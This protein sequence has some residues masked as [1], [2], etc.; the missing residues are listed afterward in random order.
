[1]TTSL[2]LKSQL[3][4]EHEP[5]AEQLKIIDAAIDEP[6]LVVA[7]AGSGK[8]ETMSNRITWLIAH[9]RIHPA[10]ILGLTFTRKAVTEL[11]NRVRKRLATYYDKVSTDQDELVGFESPQISSYN[12]FSASIISEFGYLEGI[13][14]NAKVITDTDR[15]LIAEE[16]LLQVYDADLAYQKGIFDEEMNARSFLGEFLDFADELK[17]NLLDPEPLKQW[18]EDLSTSLA[19]RSEHWGR[20]NA[21]AY[22]DRKAEFD[23]GT[24][25]EK[26]SVVAEKIKY[27]RKLLEL[28]ETFEQLK[29]E[30]GVIDFSDQ[31]SNAVQILRLHPEV[32]EVY[33][34]RYQVVILDEYQDTS[35]SQIHLL[36]LLFGD[37]HHVMAVGDPNQ[38]IYGFRGA[39]SGGILRFVDDFPTYK[40][41]QPSRAPSLT[42][43]TSWRNDTSILKA[44]NNVLE[45]VDEVH[46]TRDGAGESATEKPTKKASA[47]DC[48]RLEASPYAKAGNLQVKVC[49]PSGVVEVADDDG[50]AAGAS[51]ADADAGAD[52]SMPGGEAQMQSTGI[53][54]LDALK[55]LPSEV[56]TVADFLQEHF[57]DGQT[58]AIIS[59][60]NPDLRSFAYEL[61]ARGIPYQM[62][63]LK[64]LLDLPEIVDV[65]S[66]VEVALDSGA[67]HKLMRFLTSAQM[68]LAPRDLVEMRKRLRAENKR[69]QHRAP[70]ATPWTLVDLTLELAASHNAADE[71]TPHWQVQVAALGRKILR[72]KEFVGSSASEFIARAIAISGVKDELELL[73]RTRAYAKSQEDDDFSVRAHVNLQELLHQ[74]KNY[75][76][77]AL[78]PSIGGFLEWLAQAR[79]SDNGLEQ[80]SFTPQ[81]DAVTLIT[82]HGA[83]GLEWDIVC[84]VANTLRQFNNIQWNTKVEDFENWR[85]NPSAGWLS[86]T[87][88][89]PDKWRLDSG[90]LQPLADLEDVDSLY[91][92]D[93]HLRRFSEGVAQRGFEERARLAYVAF[94]RAKHHL[95]LTYSPLPRESKYVCHPTPYFLQA[96]KA[97]GGDVYAQTVQA[98]T[99]FVQIPKVPHTPLADQ[100]TTWPYQDASPEQEAF[101]RVAQAVNLAVQGNALA[102]DR[103]KAQGSRKAQDLREAQSARSSANLRDTPHGTSPTLQKLLYER[104]V[105]KALRDTWYEQ[106]SLP[107]LMS[108]SQTVRLAQDK[109]AFLASLA[110]P[111]PGRPTYYN[112]IGTRFHLF[113]EEFFRT[114]AHLL[115]KDA[116]YEYVSDAR[117]PHLSIDA[118]VGNFLRSPFSKSE[119]LS[120]EQELLVT[121]PKRSVITRID[122]VFEDP[123]DASKQLIVDWKTGRHP[124]EQELR[125]L[126]IQLAWYRQAWLV[127]HHELAP[128]SVEAAFFYVK[129]GE[130]G[131]LQRFST[132]YLD[133][134]YAQ[135][136]DMI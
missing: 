29:R 31:V 40:E 90:D 88:S 93:V 32:I 39:S 65:L 11:K 23:P 85:P 86:K 19:A 44:A 66:L 84:S 75:E 33:R 108:T 2:Q 47:N 121:S 96:L 10:Q 4:L 72:L 110:R 115:H 57:K 107:A 73:L 14:A 15:F 27:R 111:V 94:T 103:S 70:E 122:A 8:T 3:G 21:K 38:A 118:L 100:S 136:A 114:H 63:T 80:F 7:G 102:D 124:S 135:V 74:A 6:L 30:R 5:T 59:P 81:K 22:K 87:A 46:D 71:N 106:V 45:L 41:G 113:I 28:V 54:A 48:T 95:L 24:A 78:T 126:S 134:V 97:L 51:N 67:A 109:N 82:V 119:P 112:D 42:L 131:T 91:D 12:A 128:E 132:K 35:P 133:T 56:E 99:Q 58:A 92:Y 18:V 116:A 130:S 129:E 98:I 69:L 50:L 68:G 36:Q 61:K 105:R 125:T 83:K 1:M 17:N 43:L 55:G 123:D 104:S 26:A 120:V 89:V 76:T 62:A 77:T 101:I 49:G 34:K 13:D 117:A 20:R 127:A 25:I 37:G 52:G 79:I 9:H 53:Y 16:A 60:T 64:G